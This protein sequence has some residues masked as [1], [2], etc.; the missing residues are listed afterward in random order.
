[1]PR[2]LIVEDEVDAAMLLGKRLSKNGFD[3]LIANEVSGSI[4]LLQREKIDLM[5]LDL[6]LPAGGGVT[7]LKSLRGD[8]RTSGIPVVVLTATHSPGYKQKIMG[9]GVE[10]YMEKP[11]D[12]AE[13]VKTIKGLLK[14]KNT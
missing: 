14:N 4:E 2:I 7:V 5:I 3:I 13:L 1:M 11:Y 10:A 12:S 9:E 6:M 8:K